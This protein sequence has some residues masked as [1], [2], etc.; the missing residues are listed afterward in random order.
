M[1]IV[2]LFGHSTD[3]ALHIDTRINTKYWKVWQLTDS[4]YQD[5]QHHLL[6]PDSFLKGISDPIALQMQEYV[7]RSAIIILCFSCQ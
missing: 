5:L 1:C 4:G 7:S 3:T 6:I 2:K